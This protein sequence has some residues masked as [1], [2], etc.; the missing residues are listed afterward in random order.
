MLKFQDFIFENKSYRISFDYEGENLDFNSSTRKGIYTS[1]I[2]WLYKNGYNFKGTSLSDKIL[3]LDEVKKLVSS[4]RTYRLDHFHN[5]NNSG[6]YIVMNAGFDQLMANVVKMLSDMG[7]S[8][9]NITISKGDDKNVVDA[10]KTEK[11][12]IKMTFMEAAQYVL[13]N[14]NNNPMT[15][16]EI[17]EQAENLVKT[18][19]KTPWDS[20]NAQMILYSE[21]STAKGKKKNSLFRIIEGTKPYKFVLIN[22]DLE[23]QSIPD[24]ENKYYL[25]GAYNKNNPEISK[26]YIDG[27]YWL[28][29]FAV[30]GLDTLK[31]KVN[32]IP[33]GA[34]VAIKSSYV[35]NKVNPVI[36]IKARG[37]VTKNYND[38]TRIDVD[39]EKDF[40]PFEIIRND[41]GAY[42]QTLHDISNKQEHID[43]IWNKEDDELEDFELKPFGKFPQPFD[44][45]SELS[46][47]QAQAQAQSDDVKFFKN[48]RAVQAE[49][50]IEDFY[51]YV[52]NP[53]MQAICVLGE[54]GAGKSTTVDNILQKSG[55]N[56]QFIIPS[57]STTGLL[58][59]FSPSDNSYI[60]SRLGRM[61]ELAYKNK[62]KMYT[63]VFDECHKTNIIEMINDELLQAISVNRNKGV[64][65]ISLDDDTRRLYPSTKEDKRGNILIPNNFGFIFISS[66]ARVISGNPDFFNR[67]DL[68]ELTKSQRSLQTV[69]DLNSLRKTES[70]DKR[71]LVDKIV[72]VSE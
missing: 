3:N 45:E 69:D 5:I 52:K 8:K 65:F 34:K 13:K 24:E 39:W 66:N 48:F 53:F 32:E 28:N 59:Q 6:N 67:V 47:A 49:E 62:D 27:G 57:A 9:N 56:Y 2:D 51:D 11:S 63:A 46:K 60:P 37:I 58:S 42:R 25:L 4:S 21:N 15:G 54:S 1:I 17:W 16:F 44:V 18:S 41:V 61:I 29:G 26:Q 55:H 19:G 7:V 22:P 30:A 50:E 70:D 35:K 38:G 14:N 72:S 40:K 36:L 43:L 64:R 12:N 71:E 23:V 10:N 68:V 20:M 33:V 31:E